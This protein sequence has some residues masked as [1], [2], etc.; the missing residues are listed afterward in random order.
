MPLPVGHFLE[1]LSED[2]KIQWLGMATL[3]TAHKK[4]QLIVIY[5]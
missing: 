4:T 2:E 3:Q 1:V 5:F